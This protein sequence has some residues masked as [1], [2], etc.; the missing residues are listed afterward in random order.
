[1]GRHG[2]Q[3]GALLAL[4]RRRHRPALGRAADLAVGVPQEDIGAVSN[5]GAVNVLYGSANGLASA[6]NQFWHQGSPDVADEPERRDGF[7]YA[8]GITPSRQPWALYLPLVFRQ[9]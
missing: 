1:M 6:R 4:L 2:V 7:G 8:L 9:Q 5:S 3:L